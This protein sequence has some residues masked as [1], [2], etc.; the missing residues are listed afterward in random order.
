MEKK[1]TKDQLIA[2]LK[3]VKI[4]D[5]ATYCSWADDVLGQVSNEKTKKRQ[6]VSG[7]KHVHPDLS[8]EFKMMSM[9]VW[10]TWS[11]TSKRQQLR[12]MTYDDISEVHNMVL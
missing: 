7:E 3:K 9:M 2:Q 12:S 11:H 6:K 1:T 4:L 10:H 8:E 5:W